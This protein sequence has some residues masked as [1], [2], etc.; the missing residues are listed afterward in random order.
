MTGEVIALDEAP[1]VCHEGFTPEDIV[2]SMVGVALN[3]I[4]GLDVHLPMEALCLGAAKA[5]REDVRDGLLQALQESGIARDL[6]GTTDT[7]GALVGRTGCSRE[8]L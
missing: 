1:A 4:D 3:A 7:A 5:E 2:E 6:I 8:C